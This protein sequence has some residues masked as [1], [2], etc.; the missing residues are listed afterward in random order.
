MFIMTGISKVSDN[1][2]KPRHRSENGPGYE[3][4][5]LAG[6]LIPII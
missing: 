6:D 1:E 4:K 2:V 5:R 3:D